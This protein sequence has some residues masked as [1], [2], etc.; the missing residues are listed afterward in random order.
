[1][2]STRSKGIGD[3]NPKRQRGM[4]QFDWG[5][6]DGPSL[7]R[8][9]GIGATHAVAI[10]RGVLRILAESLGGDQR[11]VSI[12]SWSLARCGRRMGVADH[13]VQ[14]GRKGSPS[15]PGARKA[16][17][18]P[19]APSIGEEKGRALR[20]MAIRQARLERVALIASQPPE[21]D[22]PS[23]GGESREE[24]AG[25]V[26]KNCLARCILRCRDHSSRSK[27]WPVVSGQ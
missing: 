13:A 26:R 18:P 21:N 9:V 17:S 6:E 24:T 5:K 4:R 8:R 11:G 2:I 23:A 15:D 3:T 12:L 25:L 16:G 20:L 7:T 19:G 14:R 22:Q 10:G 1:M 27:Q